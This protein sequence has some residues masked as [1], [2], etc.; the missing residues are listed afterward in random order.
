[1]GI[2]AGLLALGAAAAGGAAEGERAG[3]GAGEDALLARL[4]LGAAALG[5]AAGGAVELELGA[6]RPP[7]LDGGAVSG[8]Y[9][10]PRTCRIVKGGPR[11][12][13]CMP[14]LPNSA[15]AYTACAA[16]KL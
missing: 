5:A 11:R 6:A 14:S 13:V 1:M 2:A 12:G 7:P 3:A 15:F 10:A 9:D 16:G 4:A 8:G